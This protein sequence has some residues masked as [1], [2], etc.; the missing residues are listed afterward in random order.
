MNG[1]WRSTNHQVIHRGGNFRVSVPFFFEPDWHVRV[2]PL[3]QCVERTGGEEKFREVVY[4]DHL[5]A[6]VKGNFH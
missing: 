2:R 1:L 5:I 3:K 4:G 6:K